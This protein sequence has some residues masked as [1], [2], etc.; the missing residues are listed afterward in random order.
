[1]MAVAG[2]IHFESSTTAPALEI[3]TKGPLNNYMDRMRGK[4]VKNVFFPLFQLN[5]SFLKRED[6]LSKRSL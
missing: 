1:M 4:G 5:A 3:R 2:S 6:V